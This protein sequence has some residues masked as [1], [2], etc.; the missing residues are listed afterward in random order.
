MSHSDNR[1]TH[2]AVSESLGTMPADVCSRDVPG[3]ASRNSGRRPSFIIQSLRASRGSAVS[4]GGGAELSVEV[5]ADAMMP[6]YLAEQYH[7]AN[8]RKD[9]GCLL[10]SFC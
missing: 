10:T 7:L 5:S 9:W 2:L 3:L 8:T 1:K 4:A 6:V